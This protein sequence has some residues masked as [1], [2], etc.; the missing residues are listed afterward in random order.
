MVPSIY[1]GSGSLWR[2]H[3]SAMWKMFGSDLFLRRFGPSFCSEECPDHETTGFWGAVRKEEVWMEVIQRK[4]LGFYS[5][6][7]SIFMWIMKLSGTAFYLPRKHFNYKTEVVYFVLCLWYVG[8]LPCKG[9]EQKEICFQSNG[10]QLVNER[11]SKC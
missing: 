2:G 9:G 4:P 11:K 8:N 10:I 7:C 5:C 1:S 3:K 6:C